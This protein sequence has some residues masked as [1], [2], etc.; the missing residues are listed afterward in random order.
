[1]VPPRGPAGEAVQPPY[2]PDHRSPGFR[3]ARLLI[4]VGLGVFC[5]LYGSAF[6]LFGQYV[7]PL[8]SGPMIVLAMVVIWALP[9]ARTAPTGV[10][11]ALLFAFVFF[12]VMWPNYIALARP[13]LPWITMVRLTGFPLTFVLLISL[14]T[15]KSFRRSLVQA[16]APTPFVWGSYLIF[17][18]IALLSVSLSAHVVQSLDKFLIVLVSWTAVMLASAFVF[19][20]RKPRGPRCYPELSGC[21]HRR[22]G[23][24]H[25]HWPFAQY[26]LG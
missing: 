16:L 17:L 4:A 11:V 10:L 24:H 3:L 2:T 18:A 23:L 25:V 7:I 19:M 1:M 26:V 8:L 20:S 13:G 22:R 6:A 5:L 12:L 14:S 9:E 15:S 21:R